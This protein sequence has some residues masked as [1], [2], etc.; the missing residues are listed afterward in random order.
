MFEPKE[1]EVIQA[2]LE[3]Y[4]MNKGDDLFVYDEPV[5]VTSI[6][7]KIY[8]RSTYHPATSVVPYEMVEEAVNNVFK[9]D[10]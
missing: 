8:T 3:M 6:L 7:Q 4:R 5:N 2:A 9:E 10:K 1:L